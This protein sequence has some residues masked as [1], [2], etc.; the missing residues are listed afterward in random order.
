MFDD[1]IKKVNDWFDAHEGEYQGTYRVENQYTVCED[2]LEDFRA[3]LREEFSDMVGVRCY[4]GT[5]STSIWFFEDDLKNVV[6]Y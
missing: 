6:F 3:F 1:D 5:E 2:D 4:F